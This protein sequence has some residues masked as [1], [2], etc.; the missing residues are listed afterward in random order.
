LTAREFALDNFVELAHHRLTVM[1]AGI[2]FRG[3]ASD[4]DI[5]ETA[6][7]RGASPRRSSRYVFLITPFSFNHHASFNSAGSY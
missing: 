5:V 3:H 2:F 6:P 1:A 4:N 7:A